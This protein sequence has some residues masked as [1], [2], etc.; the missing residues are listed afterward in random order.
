MFYI[1]ITMGLIVGAAF[2]WI[3]FSPPQSRK[4]S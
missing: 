4:S 1:N 3:I 2:L